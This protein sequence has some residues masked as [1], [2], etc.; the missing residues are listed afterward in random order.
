ML[1]IVKNIFYKRKTNNM[2]K[3]SEKNNYFD[4]CKNFDGQTK[5]NLPLF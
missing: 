1:I 2:K 5:Y 3:S 4:V